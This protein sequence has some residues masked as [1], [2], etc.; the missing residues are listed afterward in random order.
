MVAGRRIA[1]P[2]ERPC[3]LSCRCP[4]Y[5]GVYQLGDVNARS[6]MLAGPLVGSFTPKNFASNVIQRG[7]GVSRIHP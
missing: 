5:I 3:C 1:T 2:D 4:D 6:W 7:I